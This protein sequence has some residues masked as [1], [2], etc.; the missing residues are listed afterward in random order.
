[1]W[2]CLDST[3]FFFLQL[4]ARQ[5]PVG[6]MQLGYPKY[7]SAREEWRARVVLDP[8][9]SDSSGHPITALRTYHT[10]RCQEDIC[11]A[12]DILSCSGVGTLDASPNRADVSDPISGSWMANSSLIEEFLSPLGRKLNFVAILVECRG[13]TVGTLCQIPLRSAVPPVVAIEGPQWRAWQVFRPWSKAFDQA[14]VR[15]R[16]Y[17]TTQ[18]NQ[19]TSTALD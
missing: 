8:R 17:D 13:N 5:P 16:V 9:H 15:E 4:V 11:A 1:M 2:S 18:V 19:H 3:T 14:Y 7:R 12:L 10:R 6:I